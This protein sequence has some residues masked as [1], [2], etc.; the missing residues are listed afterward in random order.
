VVLNDLANLTGDLTT[1]DGVSLFGTNAAQLGQGPWAG[2]DPVDVL[3][4][5]WVTDDYSAYMVEYM[6]S[7]AQMWIWEGPNTNEGEYVVWPFVEAAIS[8]EVVPAPA[9]VCIAALG[10]FAAA[11]RRSR[12]GKHVAGL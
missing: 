4:F 7:T 8:F 12:G 10:A 3:S 2:D 1:T 6:T 11:L 5:D 9:T